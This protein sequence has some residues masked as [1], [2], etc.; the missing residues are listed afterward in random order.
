MFYEKMKKQIDSVQMKTTDHHLASGGPFLY[1][2][3]LYYFFGSV[4]TVTENSVVGRFDVLGVKILSIIQKISFVIC[5][6][7]KKIA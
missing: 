3:F 6:K 5:Q 7:S 4:K 2:F 1:Y